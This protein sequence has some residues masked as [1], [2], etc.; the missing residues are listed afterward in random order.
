MSW[1]AVSYTPARGSSVCTSRTTARPFV[2]LW[3][4]G[5]ALL[6]L[7]KWDPEEI[8]SFTPPVK[9]SPQFCDLRRTLN[10][11][12]HMHIFS[13]YRCLFT[14]VSSHLTF[15]S[16]SLSLSVLDRDKELVIQTR[17]NPMNVE[18]LWEMAQ[19]ILLH[20]VHWVILRFCVFGFR[21]RLSFWT[22]LD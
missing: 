14:T 11:A 15:M 22:S 2:I 20:F 16:Q 5:Y 6:S 10:L 21:T 8:S 19:S 18:L 1:I 4:S 7:P 13:Q 3:I 9:L 17:Q 12:S